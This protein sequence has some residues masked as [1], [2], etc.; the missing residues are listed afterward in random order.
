MLTRL[1]TTLSFLYGAISAP[2]MNGP[3]LYGIA[4]PNMSSGYFSTN[5][6][7]I[8]PT[9]EY[10]DVYTSPITS[11]YADVYW[12]MMPEIPLSKEI[13]S[14]SLNNNYYTIIQD[15]EKEWTS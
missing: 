10:F 11:R 9:A 12:T 1:I 14:R 3:H 7:D 8:T 15:I 6:T 13:V 5:F 2:N 4:N